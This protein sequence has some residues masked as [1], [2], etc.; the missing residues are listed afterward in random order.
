MIVGLAVATVP[1]LVGMSPAAHTTSTEPAPLPT[2]P[3]WET[4][5]EEPAP[6]PTGPNW[7]TEPAPEP[8]TSAGCAGTDW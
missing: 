7:E 4:E 5:P 6:L 2:G 1:R 3:N 8:T